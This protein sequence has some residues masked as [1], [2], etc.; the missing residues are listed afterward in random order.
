MKLLNHSQSASWVEDDMF[1]EMQRYIDE[2]IIDEM[3]PP[4]DEA[5]GSD[6]NE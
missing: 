2:R 6:E 5:A 3:N 1:D 4:Q